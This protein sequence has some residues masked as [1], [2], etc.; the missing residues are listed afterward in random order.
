MK[1]NLRRITW[2]LITFVVGA[3]AGLLL[4]GRNRA[5]ELTAER[6]TQAR[7]TWASQA[8][9]S[10]TLELRMRGALSEVRTVAVSD[11]RVVSMTAGGV[12]APESSWEYWS[13][14]GLFDVLATELANAA[15]PRR[16]VGADRVTLLARFDP[17]WGYPS[18]FYRHIMGSLNDIEW[19]VIGF[20]TD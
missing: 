14:E 19:E 5:G 2:L 4:L 17:T 13:V 7:R 15:D 3:A 9:D 16:T 12:E 1:L 18:Y 20:T 8:P 10:Y 11:G 6:L